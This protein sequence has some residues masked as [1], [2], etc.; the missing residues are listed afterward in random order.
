MPVTTRNQS[1][2]I[3]KVEKPASNPVFVLKIKPWFISVVR[4]SLEDIDKSYDEKERLRGLI[5]TNPNDKN[6][7]IYKKEIR[8]EHYNTIRRVT[9]VMYFVEQYY[10]N[11]E[12]RNMPNF[13]E[14]VYAKVQDLYKQ[15]RCFK[16]DTKPQTEDEKKC[17]AMLIYTLQDVEKMLIPYLSSS[18]PTK[19]IRKFVDYT[20]FL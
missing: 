12:V 17:I 2:N 6:N 7:R 9:E 20:K 15:I 11:P 13:G 10:P 4:K 19:R 16:P 14:V 8:I 5:N 1:K 18:Q 3:Q